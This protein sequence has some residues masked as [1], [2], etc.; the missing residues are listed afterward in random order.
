MDTEKTENGTLEHWSPS[1][2]ATAFAE[3]RIILIDVRTPQEFA[4]ERINGALLA[5]MQAFQPNHMPDQAE[6]QI[7]FHCGSGVRSARVA[8]LCLAAGETRI[9][10]MAGGFAAW[11]EAGQTYM[12]TD[13]ATGAPKEMRKSD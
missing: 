2:V 6:K 9:A 11:K 12:G 5:P 8:K 3:D 7:V 10:H 13:L 4:L 1:E